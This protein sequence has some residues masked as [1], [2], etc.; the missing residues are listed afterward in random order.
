MDY[1]IF[2]VELHLVAKS[3]DALCDYLNMKEGP[4]LLQQ[5]EMAYLGTC[6]QRIEKAKRVPTEKKQSVNKLVPS[7]TLKNPADSS[8]NAGRQNGF[9]NLISKKPE[10]KPANGKTEHKE[11]SKAD[12]KTEV[13]VIAKIGKKRKRNEIESKFDANLVID[14]VPKRPKIN[15]TKTKEPANTQLTS[16]LYS[17]DES[18]E[19]PQPENK[20]S[21]PAAIPAKP[22]PEAAFKGRKKKVYSSEEDMDVDNQ[23][24]A[25]NVAE[26][27]NEAKGKDLQLVKRKV[28]KKR[29]YQDEDGFECVSEYSD[30]EEVLVDTS[31]V[32]P[33]HKEGTKPAEGK[34][35]TAK[36]L[37]KNQSTLANFFSKKR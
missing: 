13:D 9:D 34:K 29:V 17:V 21:R 32:N 10:S 24:V 23:N 12:T 20:A 4:E 5:F 8:K 19:E 27:S 15:V 22:K 30:Y 37:D 33:P 6:L 11:E 14:D 16:N 28:K 31:K 25:P 7:K 2:E 35:H 36:P 26:A 1:E 18:S 3:H